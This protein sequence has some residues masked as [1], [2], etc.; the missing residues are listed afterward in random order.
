MVMDS[1]SRVRSGEAN[2]TECQAVLTVAGLSETRLNA[3]S[4]LHRSDAAIS[5]RNLVKHDRANV[6]GSLSENA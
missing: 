6:R 1:D 2:R 3:S 4:P 5:T